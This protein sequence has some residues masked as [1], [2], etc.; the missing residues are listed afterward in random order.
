V[1]SRLPPS[2]Q[3]RAPRDADAVRP[4]A[5]GTALWLITLVVLAIAAEPLGLDDP[6]RWIATA[7]VGAALGVVGLV[8]SRRRTRSR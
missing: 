8:I 5:V 4:V 6:G 2:S 3:E 1:D 7:A